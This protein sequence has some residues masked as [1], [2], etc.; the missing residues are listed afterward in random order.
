V[1]APAAKEQPSH[2]FVSHSSNDDETVTS[3]RQALEEVGVQVWTDSRDLAA[4]SKLKPEIEKAIAEADHFLAIL[5][6]NAINSPWVRK[7]IQFAL[8]VEKERTGTYRVIPILLPGIEPSGLGSWFDEE[9]VGLKFEVGPG[10][11]DKMLPGLLAAL[12]HRK[13][14]DLTPA[15]KQQA[16]P[17]ADL[18]LELRDPK[19]VTLGGK[20]RAQA[21]AEL[22][23][24]P[25]DGGDEIRGDN[26]FTITAPLGPIETDDIR[27]YLERYSAWANEHFTERAKEIEAKLP[28]WGR[29][30]Y[31]TLEHEDGGN[32]FQGWKSAPK[33][34]A[35]RLTV[36]VDQK[37]VS[38]AATEGEEATAKEAAT[39]L[40]GL[41]WELLY[42]EKGYLFEGTRGVRVRRRLPTRESREPIVTNPP[43]RVLLVCP[44]P[45]DEH[46][47]YIDH[48]IS[49]KPVVEA[50][51]GL[52]ELAEFKILTPPTAGALE[53]ELRT[54]LEAEK[55]YH[56][57]HFDGHGVFSQEHGLGAL[58]FEDP[59]DSKKLYKRG[60]AIV[61]S[62]ELAAKLREHRVPLFFLEACQSAVAQKDPTASVAGKLLQ[63]GVASVAAMSHSVL[64]E[65]AKRFVE[66]FYPQL[67][68]G[69][70]VGE[71]M[72]AGQR[73]LFE[74]KFRGKTFGGDLHLEDWFVP[75]LFQEEQDPQLIRETPAEDV[76][77]GIEKRQKLAL[78]ALPD[79]P[80]HTF[81]GRSR[82][83]L[84]A[85]RLL[86]RERYVVLCGEGGEGKTTLGVE[87]ARWL[88][89][90]RRFERAAFV[91]VEAGKHDDAVKALFALGTQL[92]AGYEGQGGTDHTEGLKLVER[93]LAERETLIV[94]DNM[95]SLL[96]QPDALEGVWELCR[97]LTE[98]GG[99]RLIF[100]SRE[101]LP[102]PCAANHIEISRLDRGDAVRLVAKVLG[103]E[104]SAPPPA[105]PGESEDEINRLVDAVN[106]HA[107]SLV[108]LAGEVAA[109]G[110]KAATERL[111]E[112]MAALAKKHP[113]DRERSLFA[114]VELS[115]RRL[116][117]GMRERIRG[118]G[119]FEG[120]GNVQSIGIVLGLDMEKQEHL[121]VSAQLVQVGLAEL[122]PPEGLPYLRLHP[123]LG[124]L[125]TAELSTE[126]REAAR[127]QWVE[128]LEQLTN[129]LYHHRT[130]DPQLAQNLALLELPN[131]LASLER[132]SR[133]ADA[134]RVVGMATQ[135]ESL[136]S[137]LGR[138]RALARAVRIR[139]EAGNEL[140]D[141]S[142]A[143]FL[144]EHAAVERLIDAGRHAEAVQAARA[145]VERAQAAGEEAYP[146]AAYG[147]A[148]AHVKLGH[149]LSM[150]GAA[151]A[152]L[153]PLAEARRR[154]QVLAAA[155]DRA[156]ERMASVALSE[157][158]DG[159]TD[160]GRLDEAA[161]AYEEGVRYSEER[162]D[163][164]QAATNKGQ[165]GTVRM[166]QGRYQDALDAHQEAR[167]IFEQQGEDKNVAVAL[168][169]TG[170]VH[171]EAGQP[172]AA[173]QAYQHSLQISMRTGNQASAASTLNQLG[174]LYGTMERYEEAVRF[175]RQAADISV[176][177]G[178]MKSEGV[179]RSNI[180]NRLID[181]EH[182]D[183]ARRELQRAIEC[184]QPFG[185]AAEPWKT[186]IILYNLER[187]VGD[188]A[189]AVAARQQAIGLYLAYRRD[190]GEN[191]NQSRQLYD[192]VRQALAD[193][194]A[195]QAAAQL[196]ALAEQPNLPAYLQLLI[197]ALQA[198]LSGNHD[199][200]L[201]ADPNLD[202]DDAAELQLLLEEPAGK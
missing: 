127:V 151:G 52:G 119:V 143:R 95:E 88:V 18:V 117:V 160:L 6:P 96:A 138:P 65:T 74:D 79:T 115:L 53:E 186:Y 75:V 80:P 137:N 50:L 197:P 57:V 5:S 123:A 16:K 23:F 72:L 152:A 188:P 84:A 85:E 173:E 34:V 69:R 192:A 118:L 182:Y 142:H 26:R 147:L 24:Q 62:E 111:G 32:A 194:T 7:E 110:V 21:T 54:A 183:E 25:H 70:R 130:K 103:D 87:L 19:L 17:V 145:L 170:R 190:G 76:R 181:L 178:D 162:N 2:V 189:A 11:V 47:G 158:A 187:A 13:P 77:A 107:R 125:L 148:I 27:W 9:P 71:A 20:R 1:T 30:I 89:E 12:G 135:I 112:L 44:R 185:H 10:G 128:A 199:P 59:T 31:A 28:K 164:R 8:K 40:L 180:A 38:G 200:A 157:Q 132:L 114:S 184:K 126:E 81:I 154:F 90:S 73:A 171:Q 68:K 4:G 67:L 113:D 37:L 60:T 43:I 91:C 144:T 86:G 106:C 172:E 133:T 39:Q 129:F 55:P 109:T 122:L 15:K 36:L 165:L 176:E 46:A 83:L 149:A 159:L 163:P 124:P 121:A 98:A 66:K 99:T 64:I 167:R 146:E 78:G 140:G 93:A 150:G 177:L 120:G 136:L 198:I 82:E 3:I 14:T 51:A 22:F 161:A 175:Y 169:Q 174:V 42:D 92:V 141:W 131:L 155:G 41:P 101:K 61:D 201:A 179:R 97:S 139:E 156:A 58:C 102:E 168:H 63:S 166:L 48:R 108:L 116:P 35:R 33:G 193:G 191:L 196:A 195:E 49:A 105:D 29:L 104:N 202:S 56:V 134:A 153:E 45:E 94:F 100:T